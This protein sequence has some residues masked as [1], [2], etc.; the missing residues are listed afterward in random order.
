[1]GERTAENEL[2][3]VPDQL[4]V[5]VEENSRGEVEGEEK[6]QAGKEGNVTAI[7]A[8]TPD[9][10]KVDSEERP[11]SQNK[12]GRVQSVFSLVRNQI[13][14]Q[15]CQ[16]ASKMG[17]LQLV[18]QVTRQLDRTKVEQDGLEDNS[19]R[20][21]VETQ[22]IREE[23]S[24]ELEN[25]QTME[26]SKKD[27]CVILLKQIL[28]SI[29]GLRKEV[30][31]ELNLLRQESRSNIDKLLQELSD[32]NTNTTVSVPPLPGGTKRRILRRTLTSV[33]PKNSTGQ[34]F[35]PRCMSEPVGGRNAE[36]TNTR[37]GTLPM[38]NLLPS[39]VVTQHGK[40]SVYSK[41]HVNK[42]AT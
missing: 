35:R 18:Q 23:T 16:E 5:Q 24:E 31:D 4:E 2:T 19:P 42:A 3:T 29:E 11:A 38:S 14:G 10:M 25:E 34:A 8:L 27:E 22:E 20:T 7:L 37:S 39:L 41:P 13:R 32:A 6:V 26:E 21:E 33:A 1:M 15:P 36:S 17:M 40:K 12:P 30:S 28:N 9:Q